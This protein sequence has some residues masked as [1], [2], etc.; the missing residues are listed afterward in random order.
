[1]VAKRHKKRV[2]RKHSSFFQKISGFLRTF[3]IYGKNIVLTY[4]GEDKYT[5]L[6]GG[7][8]SILVSLIILTYG[9]YLALLL[10]NKDNTRFAR[11][12][13][14]NDLYSNTDLH[15]PAAHS[16]EI[17][18]GHSQF[19]L[20]FKFEAGDI[21]L[22]NDPSAFVLTINH[23]M[24]EWVTE[25]GIR[26]TKRTYTNIEFQKCGSTHLNYKDL[27]EIYRLGID[28]YYCFKNKNYS[29]GGSYYSEKYSYL[30]MKLRKCTGDS[31]NCRNDTEL[32]D[33][34]K[35]SRFSIAIVNAIV[36]LKDYKN[37]IQH[38]ID[39]G[40]Y[41]ELIPNFRKKTD[42]FLR[43]NEASF[44]DN[45]VQLGFPQEA[46][47][48]QVAETTDRLE[49]ESTEGDMLSIYL[50]IDKITD[51]YERQIYSIGELLG[52]T[53]GFYGALIGF[54]SLFLTIFS[55]RLFVSSVLRKIYQIDSW[56]EK[57][58]L[59]KK[60]R[61]Q[62]WKEYKN[63]SIQYK[64][65][66]RKVKIPNTESEKFHSQTFGDIKRLDYFKKYPGQDQFQN[67]ILQ[68]CEQSMRERKVFKYGYKDILHYLLCCAF[69]R[70]KRSMRLKPGFREHLYFEIGQ[71]K[72]LDELDCITIIKAVRQLKL[73]TAVLLNKRQKFLMK[74]QRNNVIDSSSSGTSDEGQMNIIDL[75]ASKNKKHVEIVNKKI[76]KVIESFCDKPFQEIDKRVL[77][78]IMKKRFSDSDD[79]K[80]NDD[81]AENIRFDDTPSLH[82]RSNL[83]SILPLKSR[84][85]TEESM[86]HPQKAS[87]RDFDFV[88]YKKNSEEDPL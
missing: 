51:I 35:K 13:L 11:A 72:L 85:E 22:A 71:E 23:V 54:G 7:V 21:N 57:E 4:N 6:I 26:T 68:K 16:Y 43:K 58:M 67:D 29:I 34:I 24:Q 31:S 14:L 9:T 63:Q 42:I 86:V 48:Y 56:Q 40:L 41:W 73:L 33:L 66:G 18:T 32:V 69:C 10:I 52:Q 25:N 49:S 36:N 76:N 78:G 37:P 64:S 82:K 62:H 17:D 45:Y 12:S 3:D 28:D 61:D 60:L 87:R 84:F 8:T 1:M 5:T 74:F 59:D 81:S 53:G 27:D 39:D 55:E 80:V 79:G 20:A 65:D 30:E 44:E 70:R 46:E 88:K 83:N 75:M 2:F 38:M 50:R 15:K 19:D 77:S 47:F